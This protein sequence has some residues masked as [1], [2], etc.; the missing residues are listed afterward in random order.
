MFCAHFPAE[1]LRV[2]LCL[3]P[4]ISLSKES[5]DADRGANWS[6]EETINLINIWSDTNIQEEFKKSRRN[7]LVL[8]KV[9]KKMIEA[10]YE[11]NNGSMSEEDKVIENGL[12]RSEERK[13]QIWERQTVM[14]V[15]LT[16][17][18][19]TGLLL[20]RL[21]LL[22]LRNPSRIAKIMIQRIMMKVGLA[23]YD[24]FSASH[25]YHIQSQSYISF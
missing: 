24:S 15:F 17:C 11:R 14:S 13:Q 21:Y 5:K 12:V 25:I 3:I 10:G 2:I 16:K 7:A 19:A 9:A 23:F 8:E 18:W 1:F 22:T 20:G 4:K 6:C